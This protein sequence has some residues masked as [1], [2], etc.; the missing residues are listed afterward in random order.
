MLLPCLLLVSAPGLSSRAGDG[1]GRL[2]TI[3]TTDGEID[4]RCSMIRFLMYANEWDIRGIVHSSSKYHWKGDATHARHNW[5]DESWLDRQLDAYERVFPSLA[6]NDPGYPTPAHLRG[7]V[8]VGNVAY[9]GDM[10]RPSPGSQRIVDVLLDPDPSPVWLQ[11]WGGANTIARALK[12][13]EEEHPERV[14]EVSRKA[15]LFLIA[16]Q[17][18]TMDAYILKRWPKVE[19]ILST[20]F[21][22]IAYGWQKIMSPEE[23]AYFDARWMQA[24]ILRD[25]GP[26]A[27]LYE[28]HGD[29]RFRSEGDSPAFLHLIDVGLGSHLDPS[30]GGWGGRFERRDGRWLSAADGRDRQ[31]AILRW[32]AAFQND[33]AARADWCVQPFAACNHAPVPVCNGD[34]TKAVLRIATDPGARI[35]LSAAGSSDPD[36]NALAYRWWIY[37]DAGSYW[38]EPGLPGADT[39]DATLEV[40]PEASGR[41]IHV[42]LE[43][44]DNGSPPL[45]RYRR[46]IV[47]VSGEPQPEPE[48]PYLT[49]PILHLDGPPAGTGPWAFYRGVNINGPAIVI[50][51]RQWEGDDAPGFSCK[52]API[53][54]PR[55]PLRPATDEARA[56]MIHSF[57]WSTQ[58]TFA[59]TDIP[60]GTYA[61]YAYVWEDNNPENVTLSLNGRV[62]ARN[63]NSGVTG[64]WHR[65]GPWIVDVTGGRIELTS[66]GGAANV[67]GLEVWRQGQ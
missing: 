7:Q 39:P 25:H 36:G 45:T 63:H 62:V 32:A 58:P 16:V 52:D 56:A 14:E 2:R 44:S 57:R 48:D 35:P 49:T 30:W 18:N 19:L 1:T 60:P 50:D 23:Q 34:A 27:A 3:A 55:V 12:T 53:N 10:D 51:G 59:L 61:V 13:I 21:G 43:V 4:D 37:R 38:G 33:W 65:L 28:A 41:S 42:I 47:E 20:A 64:E 22:A 17:D 24:N 9:E 8:F 67:S 40:V 46:V 66:H 29:G 26:L 54:N 6:S 11:A 5:E 15:K 31:R